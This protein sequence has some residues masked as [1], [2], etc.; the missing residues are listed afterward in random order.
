[1]AG[2]VGTDGFLEFLNVLLRKEDGFDD[3]FRLKKSLDETVSND[4]PPEKNHL[5]TQLEVRLKRKEGAL[6]RNGSLF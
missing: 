5:F 6:G 1:M 2:E 3:Y 4:S